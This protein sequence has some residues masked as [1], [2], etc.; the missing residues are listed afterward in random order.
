[1]TKSADDAR[2]RKIGRQLEPEHLIG[3]LELFGAK[4]ST[5]LLPAV[6]RDERWRSDKQVCIPA[7][8]A[9]ALVAILLSLPRSRAGRPKLWSFD[10][11]DR[12]LTGLIND[13]PIRALAREI[14]RATGQPSGS[15][16]RRLQEIKAGGRIRELAA[17]K[18]AGKLFPGTALSPGHRPLPGAAKPIG[19]SRRR[20]GAV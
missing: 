13:K 14:S 17:L 4:A 6:E 19:P 5:F 18:K 2:L 3:V 8:V 9:D 10:I 7:E 11:E 16:R 12:V 15:V 20:P 1:M